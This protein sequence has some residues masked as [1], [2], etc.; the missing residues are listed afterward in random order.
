MIARKLLGQLAP[1]AAALLLALAPAPAMAKTLLVYGD[2]LL[3]GLGLPTAD[4]FQGQLREAL[5]KAG[6]DWKLKNASV[7][8]DTTAMGLDRLDW[9]LGDKPDAVLLELGA[10]DMLQGLPVSAAKQNL[11]AILDRF[12]ALDV[13]VMLLGMK[14]NPGLGAAY[15]GQFDGMYGDLSKTYGTALYPFYLEGVARDPKLNQA[16][17]IHPNADGVAVIVKKITPSV[18][19][20]LRKAG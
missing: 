1:I 6:L 14:A 8:G 2:S 16:D 4:A 3:A 11:S 18:V 7:S 5:D 19:E 13:P 15:A 9:A 10:N 17:G 12:K 20:F